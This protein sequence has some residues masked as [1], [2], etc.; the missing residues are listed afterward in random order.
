M[1]ET[2]TTTAGAVSN[3]NTTTIIEP[4][5]IQNK[6]P[7]PS[8]HER[9]EQL[10]GFRF[11]VAFWIVLAHNF[12]PLKNKNDYDNNNVSLVASTLHERFCVRRYVAVSFFIILSGF[13]SQIAYRDRDFNAN[14]RRKFYVGR[15][16]SV[17]ACYY[18]TMMN[19]DRHCHS[20][21][22][23]TVQEQTVVSRCDGQSVIAR[24]TA[25]VDSVLRLLWQYT[26]VDLGH[27]GVALGR[28]SHCVAASF[29]D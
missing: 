7:P 18:A 22:G 19:D 8:R 5:I 27:F 9:L 15:V 23:G 20:S 10:D 26:R 28:V 17:L 6:Q 4:T 16:G 25:N 3:S 24:I 14:N 11:L 21:S 2:T 29:E 12:E 1:D 13:V